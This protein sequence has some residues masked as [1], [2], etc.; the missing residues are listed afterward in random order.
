MFRIALVCVFALVSLVSGQ[1]G[2]QTQGE[3]LDTKNACSESRS[4]VEASLSLCNTKAGKVQRQI[5]AVTN[6]K[7]RL[8]LQT[9]LNAIRAAI[10]GT[11]VLYNN[12]TN[13]YWTPGLRDYNARRWGDAIALFSLGKTDADALVDDANEHLAELDALA[14][15]QLFYQ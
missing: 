7:N 4:S 13:D 9:K 6:A 8:A 1:A 5:N 12:N 2:A 14:C 10:S 3:A 11:R 15:D